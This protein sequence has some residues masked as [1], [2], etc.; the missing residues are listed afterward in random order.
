MNDVVGLAYGGLIADD[1]DG[2]PAVSPGGGVGE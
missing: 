2:E 1:A